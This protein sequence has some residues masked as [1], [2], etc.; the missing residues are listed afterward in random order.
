VIVNA[1][2][3]D[4]MTVHYGTT[5]GTATAGT[6]YT[7]ASG[8][9]TLAPGAT[10]GTIAFTATEDTALESNE[11]V[12]LTLGAP[13]GA[14]LGGMQTS[15]ITIANVPV[16][17]VETSSVGVSEGETAAVRVTLNTSSSNPITVHYA[18]TQEAA[19]AGTDYT[20]ASGTLTITAG[21][22]SGT[23]S[24]ATIEDSDVES[25]ET[26]LLTLT[27]PSGA[28]L[29]SSTTSTVTITN[30]DTA[31]APTVS[32]NSG[33]GGGGGG[34][35]YSPSPVVASTTTDIYALI[36]SLLAE[37]AE[38]ERKLRIARGTSAVPFSRTLREGME[39]EDVRE[40]QKYLNSHGYLIAKI[41]D[42]SP[43]NE[44]T[45]FGRATKAAL[46]RLQED[47]PKEILTPAGLTKGTG[48]FAGNTR[49]FIEAHP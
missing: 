2:S 26:F 14:I 35:W 20:T 18:T 8:T 28:F 7:A 22:T 32:P 31:P 13:S 37:V 5:D 23:I 49:K 17:T 9:L 38:L 27:N 1:S 40:L 42:G 46:V 29:G 25:D 11:T 47:H 36:K 19:T 41:G 44:T 30:D 15:T 12:L 33:G 16:I 24:I 39:G 10:S 34:G 6:D 4:T 45:Y 21:Q 48:L 3:S 43:G